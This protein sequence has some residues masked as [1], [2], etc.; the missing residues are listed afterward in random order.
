MAGA[1]WGNLAGG[2]K[3]LATIRADPVAYGMNLVGPIDW[4]KEINKTLE[5]SGGGSSSASASGASASGGTTNTAGGTTSP[6]KDNDRENQDGG[7]SFW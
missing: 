6:D 2:V 1:G 3:E 4:E 5:S 7:W